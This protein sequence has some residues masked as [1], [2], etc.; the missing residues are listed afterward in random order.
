MTDETPQSILT[1]PGYVTGSVEILKPYR[2]PLLLALIILEAIIAAS[3]AIIAV[4]LW[5]MS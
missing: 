3:T 5:R 1:S 4:L 2:D